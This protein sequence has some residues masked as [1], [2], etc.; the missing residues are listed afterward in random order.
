MKPPADAIS[1]EEAAQTLLAGVANNESI[2]VMLE[3][4]KQLWKSHGST[5]KLVDSF[6]RD[7]AKQRR[8]QYQAMKAAR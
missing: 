7:M 8:Q 1:A 3:E 5:K 4:M 2:I 6:L